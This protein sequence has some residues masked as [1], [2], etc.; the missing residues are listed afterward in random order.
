MNI[1]SLLLELV[2]LA[3]AIYVYLFARGLVNPAGKDE[4]VQTR[5]EEFRAKNGGWLRI[6]ALAL[7]A[8]MVLNIILHVR[9][10]LA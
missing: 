10:L 4:R 2:L 7:M 8:I 1:L 9:E 3:F 5:S 6:V